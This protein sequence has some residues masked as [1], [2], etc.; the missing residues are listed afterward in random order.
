MISAMQYRV[1]IEYH[2]PFFGTHTTSIYLSP[3]LAA[4]A[5]PAGGSDEKSRV[6][7]G[8]GSTPPRRSGHSTTTKHEGSF[9]NSSGRN[10]ENSSGFSSRYASICTSVLKGDTFLISYFFIKTYVGL[11]TVPVIPSS[12][13]SACVNVVFPA[14]KSPR[15][16]NSVACDLSRA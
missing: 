12:R 13:A 7:L 8:G 15:N 3:S 5:R 10:A 6:R 9:K 14:P 2:Q 1:C 16:T 11:C 4:P